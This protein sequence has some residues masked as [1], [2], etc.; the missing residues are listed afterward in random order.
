MRRVG[1]SALRTAAGL[2]S[3]NGISGH[4]HA[5]AIPLHVSCTRPMERRFAS[6]AGQAPP[7]A[8]PQAGGQQGAAA[9][10]SAA[11]RAKGPLLVSA[12][13]APLASTSQP[14]GTVVDLTAQN[15]MQV[16]Q[17]PGAVLLQVGILDEAQTKKIEKLRLAAG[18]KLP[19]ARLDPKTL[20]QI[21]QALQIRSEPCVLL[22]ARGQ[23]ADALEGDLSPNLVTAFVDRAAQALGL[24][25]DI[26]EDINEQLAEAE[27]AEWTSATAAEEILTRLESADL[28]VD[29][30][31]RIVAARARCALRLGRREEAEAFVQ[32]LTASGPQGRTPEV[33]QAQA[34]IQME[35]RLSQGELEKFQAA[36]EESPGDFKVAESYVAS[37]FW[38]GGREGEAFDTALAHL[39]K[40]K[41]DEA[42]ELVRGLVEA[43][44]PRHPRSKMARKAF[45]NAVFA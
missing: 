20:P 17:N 33:K 12:S 27:E 30:R 37:L 41:S 35:K 16:L 39:K 2:V 10:S 44:G 14:G 15:A 13:G 23:I 31:I 21:M 1:P 7:Q 18:G 4:G 32:E 5:A 22:L 9:G 40:H 38:I 24:K 19:L 29:A 8:G 25:L 36:M 26:G 3:K 28:P 45:T 6:P 43:F 42:R 11:A 34:L